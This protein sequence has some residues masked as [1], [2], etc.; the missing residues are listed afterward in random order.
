MEQL[1]LEHTPQD[2]TAPTQD[3][4]QVDH[5]QLG[6]KELK[7]W[8]LDKEEVLAFHKEALVDKSEDKSDNQELPAMD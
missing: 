2:N 7:P 4:E 6:F 1:D 3:M 8:V 5:Q